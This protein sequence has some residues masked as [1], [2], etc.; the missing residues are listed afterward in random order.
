MATVLREPIWCQRKMRKS[1]ARDAGRAPRRAAAGAGPRVILEQGSNRRVSV[2]GTGP[3]RR[4]ASM[5][6]LVIR[7]RKT[8]SDLADSAHSSPPWKHDG[9]KVIKGDRLD[10]NTAQTPGCF[11]RPRSTTRASE[12]SIWAG[13]VSIQPNANWRA[14]PR[15][16]RKRYL[17]AARQC[18]HALGRTARVHGGAGPGDFI[19]VPPFVPHQE[20][21]ASPEEPLE[22]VLVRSDNEAVVVNIPVWTRS[23]SRRGVL[24]RPHPPTTRLAR[25]ADSRCARGSR[26][27]QRRNSGRPGSSESHCPARKAPRRFFRVDYCFWCVVG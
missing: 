27:Q 12:R 19:Y 18:P 17:R 22:C 9:V 26:V 8:M 15:R 23:S 2:Q 21:N 5:D 4:G 25:F 6:R 20:I 16:A 13:T 11:G 10:P 7:W 3:G 14:P 24:G 1:F